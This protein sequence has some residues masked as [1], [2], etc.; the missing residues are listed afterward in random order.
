MHCILSKTLLQSVVSNITWCWQIFNK[1]IDLYI[2]EK[3]RKKESIETVRLLLRGSLYE[4]WWDCFWIEA[5]LWNTPIACE[6]HVE[7]CTDRLW[8]SYRAS[9]CESHL[10]LVGV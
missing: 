9:G 3:E 4:G 7:S 8:A 10:C 2:V 6:L 1:I 5:C